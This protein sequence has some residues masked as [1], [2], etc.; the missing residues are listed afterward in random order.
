MGKKITREQLRELRRKGYGA[1]KGVA[2]TEN[3]GQECLCAA[4][5][6][7]VIA[8]W[9][10]G[11]ALNDSWSRDLR[12]EYLPEDIGYELVDRVWIEND[13]PGLNRKPVDQWYDALSAAGLTHRK[14]EKK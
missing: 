3:D 6:A 13:R 2:Y 1:T 14:G 8:G 5:A 11:Y 9:S 10:P 4:G 7:L 12:M